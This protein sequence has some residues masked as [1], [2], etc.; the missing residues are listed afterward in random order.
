MKTK[1]LTNL[2]IVV[3]MLFL[4]TH[5]AQEESSSKSAPVQKSAE[6]P[7][8][9][10]VYGKP[11]IIKPEKTDMSFKVDVAETEYF[12]PFQY[13]LKHS[14][15]LLGRLGKVT[16]DSIQQASFSILE[17][18]ECDRYTIKSVR[19][20][21]MIP[22]DS[23][24]YQHLI[25]FGIEKGAPSKNDRIVTINPNVQYRVGDVAR[26]MIQSESDPR[27]NLPNAGQGSHFTY[28]FPP[29]DCPIRLINTN[30]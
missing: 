16:K 12:Q 22:K 7:C 11:G 10:C 3:C 5:C 1:F 27:I 8:D 2:G 29:F 18:G 14:Y 21:R 30:K 28:I 17:V 4:F 13:D 6:I 15:G 20:E 26:V 24:D 9:T 19:W 25:I 23:V